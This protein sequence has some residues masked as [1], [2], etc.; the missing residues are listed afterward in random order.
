MG[1]QRRRFYGRKTFENEMEFARR[2]YPNL[3]SSVLYP[4]I[5]SPVRGGECDRIVVKR[6]EVLDA[7]SV[8][9]NLQLTSEVNVSFEYDR[10]R[11]T[12]LSVAREIVDALKLKEHFVKK[13]QNVILNAVVSSL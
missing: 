12:A 5:A 7:S 6:V 1:K 9:L 4:K 13:I 8:M 10:R 3:N 2:C 11:D